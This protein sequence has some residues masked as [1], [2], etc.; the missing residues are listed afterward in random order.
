MIV[1]K[2]I[3]LNIYLCIPHQSCHMYSV[4]S[5]KNTLVTVLFGVYSCMTFQFGEITK[6]PNLVHVTMNQAPG[7]LQHQIKSN[8]ING[9]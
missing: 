8:C 6:S 4:L 3:S 7:A 2:V 5:V 9:R 1:S